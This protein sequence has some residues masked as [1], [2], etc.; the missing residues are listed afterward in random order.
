MT[1]EAR[2]TTI[3]TAMR[4]EGATVDECVSRFAA[5]DIHGP[6]Q[7]L[8]D[9]QALRPSIATSPTAGER[10]AAFLDSLGRDKAN[11]RAWAIPIP[12]FARGLLVALVATGGAAGVTAGTN[13]DSQVGDA[14]RDVVPGI[15]RL[16]PEAQSRTF[17]IQGT[18][19]VADESTGRLLIHTSD[20]TL[21]IEIHD[22]TRF[23]DEGLAAIR[24]GWITRVSGT[25]EGDSY[26]A[27]VV[28]V[29]ERHQ[30]QE[31]QG[32]PEPDVT[33]W[34]TEQTVP[35]PT[36]DAA[37]TSPP[38]AVS[39]GDDGAEEAEDSDNPAG[40]EVQPDTPPTSTPDQP[41]EPALP[42]PIEPP[43]NVP[44]L[45]VP[46]DPP[47]PEVPDVPPVVPIPPLPPLPPIPPL[48]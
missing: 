43:D 27:D 4:R 42:L 23:E 14:I 32:E 29:V 5:P 36:E 21:S 41:D 1:A 8:Y 7:A 19:L 48:P 26:R 31:E 18:V 30:R 25:I 15:E 38:A 20:D 13:L 40:N 33:A 16:L 6:V 34:S 47:L 11:A 46:V 2:L 45:P 12:G 39:D 44:P 35:A 3:L 37:E 17:E 9:L 22:E 24:V 10:K 28:E